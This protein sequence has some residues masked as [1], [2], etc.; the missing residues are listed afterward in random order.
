M[1]NY[2]IKVVI[3]EIFNLRVKSN[4]ELNEKFNI[5]NFELEN[6]VNFIFNGK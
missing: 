2:E 6:L 1:N 5:Y 3:N 4:M